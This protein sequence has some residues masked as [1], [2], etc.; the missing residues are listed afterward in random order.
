MNTQPVMASQPSTEHDVNVHCNKDLTD[1]QS[2][3]QTDA[4]VLADH[5]TVSSKLPLAS[6][7]NCVDD[8]HVASPSAVT[9]SEGDQV[10]WTESLYTT[11]SQLFV[12]S[13][14]E[15]QRDDGTPVSS[16]GRHVALTSKHSFCFNFN[17][18][19]AA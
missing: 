10:G 8:R 9:A 5:V 16:L 3:L 17:I 13:H 11:A 14:M 2:S 4:G 15:V 1:G 7:T 6:Q 19:F 18:S 12:Q